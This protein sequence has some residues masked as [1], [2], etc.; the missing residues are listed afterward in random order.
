[1]KAVL[2]RFASPAGFAMVLLLFGVLPFASVS[3][4]G[5]EL[6]SA[7]VSYNGL[8]LATGT[9]PEVEVTG[10][11]GFQELADEQQRAL[12]VESGDAPDVQWQTILL[13]ALLTGGILA[14]RLRALAAALAGVAAVLVVVID[15]IARVNLASAVRAAAADEG[16]TAPEIDGLASEGVGRELGFWV[17]VVGLVVLAVYNLVAAVRSRAG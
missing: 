7:S 13:A 11:E 5:G 14:M 9:S 10:V 6:G 16:L 1:M 12:P 8:D 15:L 3:C 2:A 17:T 4:E